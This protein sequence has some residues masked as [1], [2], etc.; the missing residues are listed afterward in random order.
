[1]RVKEARLR[2]LSRKLL[3]ELSRQ[4]RRSAPETSKA[5]SP[6]P[7]KLLKLMAKT[8]RARHSL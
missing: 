3:K 4:K 1:M 5:G 7:K 2:E 6:L 8:N